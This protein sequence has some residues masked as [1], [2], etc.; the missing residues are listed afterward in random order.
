MALKIDMSKAYDRVKWAF[1]STVMRKMNFLSQWINLVMDCIS[2]S[3]LSF[4]LN[5]SVVCSLSPSRGLCQGCP[6]SPYLF[7]LCYEAL[8]RFI[9]KFERNGR[10]LGIR[11]CR[12]SPLISHLFFA[13]DSMRFSK[14]SKASSERIRQILDIYEEGS[15]QKMNLNK[16]IITFSPDKKKSL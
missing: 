9:T 8:S 7:L 2:S 13:D 11:S 14:A 15:G 16:S 1:L 3:T 10:E 12:G 5:G 4:Q 6:L